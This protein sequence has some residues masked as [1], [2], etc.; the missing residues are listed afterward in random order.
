MDRRELVDA[1]PAVLLGD[2]RCTVLNVIRASGP[3]GVREVAAQTGLHPNTVRFHLDGLVEAGLAER[4]VEE[5][6]RPGRPRTL[7]RAPA[8]GHGT[9]SYRLLAQILTSL[10]AGTMP[11]P[12]ASAREAGRAWGRYLTER[13]APFERIDAD[14]ALDRLADLLADIGFVSRTEPTSEGTLIR[15]LHCPFREVA[16]EHREIICPLHL[17]LIQGAL[18]EMDAPLG[19]DRLEPFVEPNLCLAHISPEAP[20]AG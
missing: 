7:Y 2:S 8:D 4:A 20:P 9:R 6:A 18:A 5:R 14:T 13:P 1:E 17:G 15:L 16:E 3:M 10:I 11:D 12:S 19:A